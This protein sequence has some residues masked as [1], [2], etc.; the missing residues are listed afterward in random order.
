[1][2]EAVAFICSTMA[3]SSGPARSMTLDPETTRATCASGLA[4]VT[5]DNQ[6]GVRMT[7]PPLGAPKNSLEL[8]T[9]LT[10]LGPWLSP[11]VA[12]GTGNFTI[13]NVILQDSTGATINSTINGTRAGSDGY[14]RAL[15]P[16]SRRPCDDRPLGLAMKKA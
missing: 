12:P 10:R 13:S 1:M 14:T 4:T 15:Y 8:Y 2:P 11:L 16:F 6:S 5:T 3:K 9:R 7:D